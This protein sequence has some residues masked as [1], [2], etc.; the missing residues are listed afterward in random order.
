MSETTKTINRKPKLSPKMALENKK[1]D[2]KQKRAD[3]AA[4]IRMQELKNESMRISAEYDYKI[5]KIRLSETIAECDKEKEIA[6]INA[7]KEEKISAI[8]AKVQVAEMEYRKC[9]A[10]IFEKCFDRYAGSIE[11]LEKEQTK[12]LQLILKFFKE[13]SEKFLIEYNNDISINKELLQ[14]YTQEAMTAKGKL[15][16]I[17]INKMNELKKDL[18]ASQNQKNDYI[19][20]Y[21]KRM[22]EKLQAAYEITKVNTPNLQ[23]LISDSKND[24][25][26]LDSE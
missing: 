9:I 25:L 14:F 16:L 17:C 6:R 18:R 21:D 23:Q 1:E 13:E 12:R 11:V 19:R 7:E 26:L 24:L 10:E 22:I 15:K 20:S 3:Q 4:K 8:N 5:A 2:N